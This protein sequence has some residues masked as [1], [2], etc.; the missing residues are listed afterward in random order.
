MGFRLQQKS[1]VIME[2]YQGSHELS[3]PGHD[4]TYYR[5]CL[6]EDAP[7]LFK[8]SGRSEVEVLYNTKQSTGIVVVAC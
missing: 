1:R 4:D 8:R 6:N 5:D 3:F 2:S 7:R